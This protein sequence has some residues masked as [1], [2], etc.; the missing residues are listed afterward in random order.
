MGRILV[1]DDQP[2]IA[3]TLAGLILRMG[4]EV[5]FCTT[6]DEAVEIA[7]KFQPEVA[8][9]DLLMPKVNGFECADRLLKR[10]SALR[11]IAMSGYSLDTWPDKPQLFEKYLLKPVRSKTI[12]DLIG[13]GSAAA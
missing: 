12:L 5:R 10:D 13:D 7:E 1:V 11:L 6:C 3:A 9:V 2:D 8:F 4:H